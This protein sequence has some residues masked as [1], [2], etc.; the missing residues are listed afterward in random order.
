MNC[1]Q[2]QP[3]GHENDDAERDFRHD[4]QA[5]KGVAAASGDRTRTAVG[6][7]ALNVDA[8]RLPRRQ[9]AEEQARQAGERETGADRRAV[10]RRAIPFGERRAADRLESFEAGEGAEESERAAHCGQH[11]ALH[12][13]LPDHGA[14]SAAERHARGDLLHARSA[15]RHAAAP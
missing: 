3:R 5:A 6:Q 14:A 10:E 7:R 13:Q 1:P 8:S 2:E 11:H 15:A 4:Q 12:H 9:E